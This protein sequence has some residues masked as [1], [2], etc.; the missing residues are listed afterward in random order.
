MGRII[1]NRFTN[2]SGE[3]AYARVSE[4]SVGKVPG[5]LLYIARPG[6]DIEMHV[7]QREAMELKELLSKI[8]KPGRR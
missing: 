8:L 6:T 3:E 2:E 4:A 1:A 5:V 7:T